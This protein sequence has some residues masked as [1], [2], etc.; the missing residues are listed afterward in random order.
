MACPFESGGRFLEMEQVA[1]VVL[2]AGKGTRMKS[3]R[4]KVLHEVCGKSMI[5]HVV[6][7]ASACGVGQVVVVVGHQAKAV[8][9]EVGR[10]HTAGFALQEEQ[11]GTGHAVKMAVPELL[12][13]ITQIVVLCG[14]TPLVR[15]ETLA[16]LV[17]TH[18]ESALDMTVLAVE[19]P[20]P[21]GYGRIVTA[22]DGDVLRI[23]EEAD[24]TEAERAI[25]VVNSGIYCFDRGFL[26]QGLQKIGAENA[27][28]EYYLTDMVSIGV[29][30]GRRVGVAMGS[31]VEELIGVNSP[32]DLKRADALMLQAAQGESP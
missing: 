19:I 30:G 22:A 3:D 11:L 6:G 24:A 32:E 27:Q 26:E 4:A 25:P 18:M 7:A 23:V 10:F 29:A 17:T 2:A 21:K 31:R 8:R 5:S 13:T 1:V 15:P 12:E 16:S 28:E 14:D 20:D 9:E